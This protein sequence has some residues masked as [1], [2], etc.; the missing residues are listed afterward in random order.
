M[1]GLRE[2]RGDVE[3]RVAAP[4][5]GGAGGRGQRLELTGALAALRGGG[6]GKDGGRRS[7]ATWRGVDP[8]LPASRIL[9]W[10]NRWTSP[11]SN[12]SGRGCSRICIYGSEAE[13]RRA[14]RPT[15]GGR[16]LSPMP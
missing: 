16:S 12:R 3:S 1:R 11:P 4:D 8:K 10:R 2:P 14:G 15:T 9:R 7:G 5:R 6:R 13:A